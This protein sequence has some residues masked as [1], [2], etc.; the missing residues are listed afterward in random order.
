MGSGHGDGADPGNGGRRSS[1]WSG[2]QFGMLFEPLAEEP[3]RHECGVETVPGEHGQDEVGALSA[4][5]TTT[6]AW[7][8]ASALAELGC[9]DDAADLVMWVG[10][11]IPLLGSQRRAAR[12]LLDQLGWALPQWLEDPAV[13]AAAGRPRRS[14]PPSHLAAF[15]YPTRPAAP[16]T[17]PEARD[18]IGAGRYDEAA[19]LLIEQPARSSRLAREVALTIAECWL[20]ADEPEAAEAWLQHRLTSDGI[21]ALICTRVQQ[22]RPHDALEPLITLAR[23]RALRRERREAAAALVAY[24]GSSLLPAGL[25]EL[26]G[27]RLL[28]ADLAREAG[29]ERLVERAVRD[30]RRQRGTR[31]VE[32]IVAQVEA[33]CADI[34]EESAWRLLLPVYDAAVRSNPT[35]TLAERGLGLLLPRLEQLASDDVASCALRFA[36]ACGRTS[37]L[38]ELLSDLAERSSDQPT[39]FASWMVAAQLSLVK[40]DVSAVEGDASR[41]IAAAR[42]V[43]E[44]RRAERLKRAMHWLARAD[45]PCISQWQLRG[46]HHLL[47]LPVAAR[48]E[49]RDGGH[50]ALHEDDGGRSAAVRESIDAA[51]RRL[52]EATS[53]GSGPGPPARLR[54]SLGNWALEVGCA[55][56]DADRAVEAVAFMAAAWRLL[57]PELRGEVVD[58]F[59]RAVGMACRGLEER[60]AVLAGLGTA[61]RALPPQE[62]ASDRLPDIVLGAWEQSR[63]S[64]RRP[65]GAQLPQLEILLR[66][67]SVR[68]P[69][70]SLTLAAPALGDLATISPGVRQTLERCI[71]DRETLLP[72]VPPF[73]GRRWFESDDAHSKYQLGREE[74]DARDAHKAFEEAWMWEPNNVVTTQGLILGLGRRLSEKPGR[75]HVLDHLAR[76][77]GQMKNREVEAALAQLTLGGLATDP[78]ERRARLEPAADALRRRVRRQ[79]WNR[80]RNAE[81]AI[82]LELGSLAA[83]GDAAWKESLLCLPGSHQ[84]NRYA[85]LAAT[86]WQRERAPDRSLAGRIRAATER[87]RSLELTNR[88]AVRYAVTA[89][90]LTALS[91]LALDDDALEDLWWAYRGDERDL[92]NFIEKQGTSSANPQPRYLRF[93]REKRELIDPV[94]GARIDGV[95][96]AQHLTGDQPAELAHRDATRWLRLATSQL[97]ARD[98]LDEAATPR[99]KPFEAHVREFMVELRQRAPNQIAYLTFADAVRDVLGTLNK[100]RMTIPASEPEPNGLRLTKASDALQRVRWAARGFSTPAVSHAADVLFRYLALALDQPAVEAYLREKEKRLVPSRLG[101]RLGDWWAEVCDA[102]GPLDFFHYQRSYRY[103]GDVPPDDWLRNHQVHGRPAQDAI[104]LL[105]DALA[106]HERKLLDIE[107][108]FRASRDRSGPARDAFG[109]ESALQDCRRTL[110]RALV[111]NAEARD[112]GALEATLGQLGQVLRRIDL[113]RLDDLQ[114]VLHDNALPDKQ[115]LL[116]RAPELLDHLRNNV[117]GDGCLRAICEV[118]DDAGRQVCCLLCLDRWDGPSE[119][120]P[121]RGL[122]PFADL[123]HA[124]GGQLHLWMARPGEGARCRRVH[125]D[126]LICI[127][128]EYVPRIEKELRR[129]TRTRWHSRQTTVEPWLGVLDAALHERG[130]ANL[131]FV[132]LPRLHE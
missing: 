14:A 33:L 46:L 112:L 6:S 116:P 25:E 65:N 126:G 3:T 50:D 51:D 59:G 86:L 66:P 34:R 13:A 53:R 17:I 69:L 106:G 68:R 129:L 119:S 82:R 132:V 117:R 62:S 84:S 81:I 102:S 105:V 27:D 8:Q 60:A 127:A 89:G 19:R 122:A 91:G 101:N 40:N 11:R 110:R 80:A 85:L 123:T 1:S 52:R 113:S 55:F 63:R 22:N 41:A 131:A 108:G 20:L 64:W 2:P 54:R 39:R 96:S 43:A 124:L 56:L 32:Q 78:R 97:L 70:R 18:A 12:A 49:E 15:F 103:D 61:L 90:E 67:A 21:W 7:A 72:D 23:R 88:D 73:R 128:D 118:S 111:P 37:E 10:A 30:I 75:S 28:N 42:S 57:H 77:L 29:N 79:P 83:A 100:L 121:L 38:R 130:S 114:D 5:R 93:L 47:P 94:A 98:P 71:A 58:A 16:P 4:V 44:E 48:L 76:V 87:V 95:R 24:L 45:G 99:S 35:P 109:L 104:R 31:R 125:N 92:L 115:Y 36:T 120:K 107:E 26:A 9:L 74:L